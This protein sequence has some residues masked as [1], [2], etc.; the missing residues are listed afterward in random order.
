MKFFIA[1]VAFIFLSLFNIVKADNNITFVDMDKIISTSQPGLLF[2]GQL[3]DLN[4][5][6]IKKFK[7]NE[8]SLKTREEKIIAQKNIISEAAFKK[9]I[10][11]LRSD[12]QKYNNDKRKMIKDFNKIKVNNT[13]RLLQLINPILKNYSE[14]NSI[15]LILQKKNLVIGKKELDITDKIILI[16]NKN[17]KEFE[18]K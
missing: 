9:E 6:N 3:R 13:N 15:S 18:I 17:I 8:K 7:K 4:D 2:L 10:M 5:N 14:D 16:I 12:V 1:V 11:T